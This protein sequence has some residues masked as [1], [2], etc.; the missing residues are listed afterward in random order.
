MTNHSLQDEKVAVKERHL[1]LHKPNEADVPDN[2][3]EL[4]GQ[5]VEKHVD[6]DRLLEVAEQANVPTVEQS[7]PSSPDGSRPRIAVARDDA[8]CFYYTE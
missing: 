7:S 5:L 1:G 2:H 3:A 4:L 6:L 8:F